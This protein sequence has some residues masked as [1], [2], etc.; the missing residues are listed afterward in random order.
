MRVCLGRLTSKSRL[1]SLDV[2][3]VYVF[4]CVCMCV[5]V[6]AR[7]HVLACVYVC[8]HVC[9]YVYVQHLTLMQSRLMF[10]V[11]YEEVLTLGEHF[12]KVSSLLNL[13]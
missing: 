13:L 10:K 8:V 2:V 3:C 4:V 6:C 1:N 7:A 11:S 12:S 9:V 5:C